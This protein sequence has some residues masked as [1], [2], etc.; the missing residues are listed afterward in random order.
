MYAKVCKS[1]AF[2]NFSVPNKPSLC[3]LTC[4]I[5]GLIHKVANDAGNETKSTDY[6]KH[7]KKNWKTIK[8]VQQTFYETLHAGKKHAAGLKNM[9]E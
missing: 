8:Y 6:K 5:A 4:S 9:N 1:V 7:T 3:K 2:V